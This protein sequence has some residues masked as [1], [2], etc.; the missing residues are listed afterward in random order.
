M[1]SSPLPPEDP[2]WISDVPRH[3]V[4]RTVIVDGAFAARFDDLN[5]DGCEVELGVFARDDGRWTCVGHQDD[6]NVPAVGESPLYGWSES[7]GWAVGRVRPGERLEIEWQGERAVV[8]TDASGWWLAVVPGEP[9][10]DDDEWP[11]Y[12]G[13]R[14]RV[15]I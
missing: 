8:G 6:V 3:G 4:V 9:P 14:T 1:T 5:G 12:D 7:I 11:A 10:A 2:L 15:I 13:P